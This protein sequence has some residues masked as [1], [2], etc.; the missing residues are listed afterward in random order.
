MEEVLRSRVPVYFLAEDMDFLLREIV[1][2]LERRGRWVGELRL[3]HFVTGE[4]IPVLW[5][6][7]RVDDPETGE[8]IGLATVTR[9]ITERKKAE[10]EREER[11]RQQAVVA[12]LGLR[13]LAAPSTEPLT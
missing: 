4:P 1:P 11:T 5:D 3:R 6:G 2:E 9:D 13:A 10:E 8:P 12:D 7:F